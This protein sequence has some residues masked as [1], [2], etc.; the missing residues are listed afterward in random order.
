M[1]TG[2]HI[3]LECLKREGVDTIFGYPGAKTLLVHDA[4][5][6]DPD[7]RHMLE[8]VPG[9]GCPGCGYPGERRS[10]QGHTEPGA[11]SSAQLSPQED[12]CPGQGALP[13]SSCARAG[14]GSGR[15]PWLVWAGHQC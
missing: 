5:Y 9:P 2:A 1:K 15:L 10:Q 3:L 8:L 4:L 12:P 14:S 13:S 11:P 7:L 6:D